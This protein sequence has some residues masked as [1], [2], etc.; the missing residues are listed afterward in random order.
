MWLCLFL[1]SF[2]QS[3]FLLK[4]LTTKFGCKKLVEQDVQH[5]LG[6]ILAYRLDSF[7]LQI[8]FCVNLFKRYRS[9]LLEEAWKSKSIW[10]IFY[11]NEKIWF[12]WICIK[13]NIYLNM[14]WRKIC[15]WFSLFNIVLIFDMKI[16]WFNI[17]SMKRFNLDVLVQHVRPNVPVCVQ[18]LALVS[19]PLWMLF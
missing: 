2:V 5:M 8:C 18:N 3:M 11:L 17:H 13:E 10:K 15:F 6:D 7:F 4:C 19:M 12:D 1:R 14:P 16:Y 9:L